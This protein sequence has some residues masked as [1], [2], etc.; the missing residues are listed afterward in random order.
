MN[1]SRIAYDN[2]F[3]EEKPDF[4]HLEKR[5]G[6]LR[7][8]VEAVR[9]VAESKDWATLRELVLDDVVTTLE[10]QLS[11]EAMKTPIDEP[12]LYRLQGQ[13]AWAKK[14]VDLGQ[15][16]EFF[17]QQIEGIK[18]LTHEQE[19]LGDGAPNRSSS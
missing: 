10:R 12:T 14:Y 15:L 18:T 4:S 17:A 11:S 16:A 13:L 5:A 6:E 3:E 1:N 9:R 19:N 8:I 7:V 2:I